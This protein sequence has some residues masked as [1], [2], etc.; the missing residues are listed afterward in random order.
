M[1]TRVC[2]RYPAVD[3]PANNRVTTVTPKPNRFQRNLSYCNSG[4][5]YLL[6]PSIARSTLSL[7]SSQWKKIGSLL[8]VYRILSLSATEF[9]STITVANPLT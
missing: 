8:I 1:K 4:I 2:F 9:F 6:T 5:S 7:V 3:F